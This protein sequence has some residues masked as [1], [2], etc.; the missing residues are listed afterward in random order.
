MSYNW[1]IAFAAS[2][3]PPSLASLVLPS[4]HISVPFAAGKKGAIVTT[5]LHVN[6]A[7]YYTVYLNLYFDKGNPEDRSHV[8]ALAGSGA[9]S[10]SG[11]RLDNGLE[12]PVELTIVRKKDNQTNL[13]LDDHFKTDELGGFTADHFAKVITG[14]RLDPGRYEIKIA[15]LQD[16]PEL[17]DVPV[18][19]DVHIRPRK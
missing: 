5:N 19:F 1:L 15:A 7:A 10:K 18:R 12:I 2:V 17:R 11:Q 13:I 8:A 9:T 3:M 16:V 6:F 4:P 14:I